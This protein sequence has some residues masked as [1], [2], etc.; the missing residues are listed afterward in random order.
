MKKLFT[1]VMGIM[2]MGTAAMASV[3]TVATWSAYSSAWATAGVDEGSKDTIYVQAVAGQYTS[4]AVV[5]SDG[6]TKLGATYVIGLPDEDGNL[7]QFRNMGS[8]KALPGEGTT[9]SII[10]ENIHFCG[11]GTGDNFLVMEDN[12]KE[13]AINLDTLAVRN[14][15]L[16]VWRWGIRS[17]YNKSGIIN[18]L[19]FTGNKVHNNG[20]PTSGEFMTFAHRVAEVNMCNNTFYDL[21]PSTKGLIWFNRLSAD[22]ETINM[23]L[24]FENNLVAASMKNQTLIDFGSLVGHDSWIEINNNFFY[25]PD[26]ESQ[27]VTAQDQVPVLRTEPSGELWKDGTSK[28]TTWYEIYEE[29]LKDITGADSTVLRKRF[30]TIAWAPKTAMIVKG[31]YGTVHAKGNVIN[32]GY[33]AWNAGISIDKDGEGAWNNLSGSIDYTVT[34]NADGSTSVRVEHVPST[35]DGIENNYTPEE[36]GFTSASWTMPV[37][38]DFSLWKGDA[39]GTY[40]KGTDE[41]YLPGIIGPDYWYTDVIK[42]KCEFSVALAGDSKSASLTVTPQKSQY[43][44]GDEVKM[45]IDLKGINEFKGWSDASEDYTLEG[46]YVTRYV[47]LTGDLNLVATVKEQDYL[48]IWDISNYSKNVFSIADTKG[49]AANYSKSEGDCYFEYTHAD[50][51]TRVKQIA[52]ITASTDTLQWEPEVIVRMDTTW[53]E[54]F[55]EMRGSKPGKD[56]YVNK[57]CFAVKTAKELFWAGEGNQLVATVNTVNVSGIS[58]TAE[59]CT[60]GY[61]SKSILIEYSVDGGQTW[62]SAGKG[63]ISDLYYWYP[64]N[65]QL[66]EAANGQEALK[67]RFYG[68]VNAERLYP[69]DEATDEWYTEETVVN[70][71]WFLSAIQ[72]NAASMLGIQMVNTDALRDSAIYD[73]QGRR[74]LNTVPGMIYIQA[75]KK[76]VQ[77]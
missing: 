32:G 71:F 68:D 22:D 13:Y 40:T 8:I 77:Q 21:G 26:W 70:E 34:T 2:A 47:T 67:V 51:V 9:T 53:N 56:D 10:V 58:F 75:G 3:T 46:N 12:K 33:S 14:C 55:M 43:F 52:K 7:P 72:F 41:S 65:I 24:Y 29:V 25:Y 57:P 20:S 49:F 45:V 39:A 59:L 74:V 36:I 6:I 54:N 27:Y 19:D 61:T 17:R 63:E 73:M 62:V 16:E 30:D 60:D 66:P 1:L 38:G 35:I 64:V 37:D 15:E 18:Y 28:D 4:R 5:A 23:N 44:T 11:T 69:Y 42:Q 76:F 50:G 31:N 48:A